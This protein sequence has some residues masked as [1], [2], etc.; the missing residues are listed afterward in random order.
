MARRWTQHGGQWSS[1]DGITI[2]GSA[3]DGPGDGHWF[4]TRIQ[5]DMPF[6]LVEQST[7]AGALALAD[8]VWAHGSR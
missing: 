1:D 4:P 2:D 5:R 3:G 8:E 7:P 6:S